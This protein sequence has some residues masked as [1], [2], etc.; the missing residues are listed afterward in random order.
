[1]R[2]SVMNNNDENINRNN[3]YE[4]MICNGN[5]MNIFGENTHCDLTPVP[6]NKPIIE[7]KD[8]EF[9]RTLR[10]DQDILAI[11]L[12]QPWA[13]CIA[14]KLCK[15]FCFKVEFDSD[16]YPSGYW[17][18][19]RVH[20]NRNVT[21]QVIEDCELVST[22]IKDIP[23][24]QDSIQTAQHVIGFA[25]VYK[26]STCIDDVGKIHPELVE[27]YKTCHCGIN[28]KKNN[29]NEGENNEYNNNNNNN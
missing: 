1:M 20:A 21:K 8:E 3:Y 22:V 27:I 18:A 29:T 11:N 19:I 26:S 7:L 28:K 10:L 25:H 24:I 14:N 4:Q 13:F 16:K 15:V 17:Y 2:E 12:V 23:V 5:N 6:I 9:G